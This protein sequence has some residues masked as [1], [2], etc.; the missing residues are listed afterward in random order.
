MKKHEKAFDAV[1]TMR[2][3]RDRLSE[4]FKNLSFEEQKRY[5]REHV[6]VKSTG[7]RK[8]ENRKQNVSAR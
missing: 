6:H 3:I 8:K 1:K 7:A 5:I 2:A 4:Q